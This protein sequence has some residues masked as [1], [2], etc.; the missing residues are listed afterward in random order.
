MNK[1]KKGQLTIY[2]ILVF[3]A[4]VIMLIGAIVG[5][6]GSAL[7]SE[8]YSAGD[9]IIEQAKDPINSIQDEEIKQEILNSLESAQESQKFNIDFNAFLYQYSWVFVILILA[10]IGF[11]I[12][13]MQIESSRI[14]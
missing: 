5:P 7:A 4:I 6:F 8:L 10:L 1:S 14:V 3:I 12:T 11:I 9:D 2:I 13:R